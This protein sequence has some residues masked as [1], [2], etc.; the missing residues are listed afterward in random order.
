LIES[1][2]GGAST[3][4]KKRLFRLRKKARGAFN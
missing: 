2:D 4:K 3:K 1:V